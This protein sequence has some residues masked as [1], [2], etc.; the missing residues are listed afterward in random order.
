[1]DKIHNKPLADILAPGLKVLFIGYNPGLR[2]AELGH[3]YAG[4]SNRFWDVLYRAGLTTEKL[5]F[6]RDRE[7]LRYGYG[8]TNIIDR[9]SKS[10]AELTREEYQAGKRNLK[11]VLREYHPAIACYVGIDVYKA[12]SGKSRV[13]WGLQP[14]MTVEGIIDF[15]APST[16]GL[17]RMPAIVQIELYSQLK[18]LV[19]RVERDF[20]GDKLL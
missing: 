13:D 14:E 7:L 15:V 10:A 5:D 1:M 19:D 11:E 8:S 3:H 4:R 9:P 2:S 16:S 18:K 12:F 20:D 6:F 17:N